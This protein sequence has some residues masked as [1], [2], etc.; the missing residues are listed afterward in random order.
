MSTQPANVI[1]LTQVINPANAG[2]GQPIL[3]Y[4]ELIKKADAYFDY[5]ET[6][7]R[8]TLNQPL[9]ISQ[10]A[11]YR[12]SLNKLKLVG[13][14]IKLLDC[15]LEER[16]YF[17]QAFSDYSAKIY[18]LPDSLEVYQL[19]SAELQSLET[20]ESSSQVDFAS[21]DF[22]I[23]T[24]QQILPAYRQPVSRPQESQLTINNRQ[25]AINKLRDYL[26]E[27]YFD[28]WLMVDEFGSNQ[29]NGADLY[30]LIKKALDWLVTYDDPA[31][32]IW[33]AVEV[34]K[35]TFSVTP[36]LNLIN[37]PTRR[38]Y[39]TKKEVKSILAH[40]LLVHARRML[41]SHQHANKELA[42]FLVGYYEVEEGLGILFEQA[43]AGSLPAKAYDRYVDIGLALGLLD[44]VM[45]KR[46]QIYQISYARQ[47][48]R[49]QLN[50]ASQSKIT[51]LT[52]SV[53]TH[54]DRL[55]RGGPGDDIGQA[56]AIFTKDAVYYSGY[57]K[58]VDFLSRA[59]NSGKS[60]DEFYNFISQAKFNPLDPEHL[61]LVG[62]L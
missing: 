7:F 62:S 43:I 44:G 58:M 38:R 53:W 1:F 20:L 17:A 42:K 48:I 61:K 22:L 19:I 13:C 10:K 45:R 40:E 23:K 12:R 46:S 29:L 16:D 25:Q 15:S 32:R 57:H 52:K 30:K 18:S 31:W 14:A 35:F 6:S 51:N 28:L 4:P 11:N 50:Q 8:S 21:R 56:Q 54:V 60:V 39:L 3:K 24:Y 9:T 26:L 55:Y 49:L 34:N 2:S 33:Q 36:S 41:K 47:L 59:L 5:L 37:I 27:R